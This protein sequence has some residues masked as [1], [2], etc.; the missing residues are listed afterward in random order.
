MKTPVLLIA[1]NRPHHTKQTFEGIKKYQPETLYVSIDGPREVYHEDAKLIEEVYH[2]I[3]SNVDWQCDLKIKRN[4]QNFGAGYASIQAIDWLFEHEERGIILDDDC[5]AEQ[6]FFL[7]CEKMLYLYQKQD[8]IMHI[9]GSN[10]LKTNISEDYFFSKYNPVWGWATWKRAWKH[11]AFRIDFQEKE[12]K[13]FHRNYALTKKERKYWAYT[14]DSVSLEKRTST[15]DYQWTYHIW[16]NEGICITAGKNLI[17]NIGFDETATHANDPFFSTAKLPLES[18]TI[19][20]S[21]E[22]QIVVNHK[23]DRLIFNNHYLAQGNWL[24]KLKNWLYKKAP[25][26][27]LY[28]KNKIMND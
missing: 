2:Y 5:V 24:R 26:L 21:T 22:K 15:W 14:F 8:K 12:I 6:D 17:S 13:H 16:K 9:S 20:L 25:R 19:K 7:F 3:Q 23:L 4:K 10:F 28:V 18:L 11:Y 27:Y 1:F